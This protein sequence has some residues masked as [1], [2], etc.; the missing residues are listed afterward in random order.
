VLV[1]IVDRDW[2]VS[3]SP[4]AVIYGWFCFSEEVAMRPVRGIAAFVRTAKGTNW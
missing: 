4:H 3:G 1:L 2:V